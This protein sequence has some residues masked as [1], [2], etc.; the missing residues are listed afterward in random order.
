[1][2]RRDDRFPDMLS[3]TWFDAAIERMLRGEAV[4]EDVAPL[5]RVVD[6]MRVMADG[7]PPV[8]SPEL[9]ALLDGGAAESRGLATV[10]PLAPLGPRAAPRRSGGP[11]AKRSRAAE[12]RP[13]VAAL[14]VASKVALALG[15][16]SGVAASGAAGILPE[17]ATSVVRRAIEVMTPFELPDD[18]TAGPGQDGQPE[19]DAAATPRN[20]PNAP[21]PPPD[22]P[23]TTIP[24]N[25]AA[26]HDP[27]LGG[28]PGTG[29]GAPSSVSPGVDVSSSVGGDL[30]T[31]ASPSPAPTPT[32]TFSTPP[33]SG[34]PADRPS[35]L[36]EPAAHPPPGDDVPPAD[37]PHAGPP[38][39]ASPPEPPQP[40]SSL[41]GGTPPGSGSSTLNE[42]SPAAPDGPP[43]RSASPG[44]PPPVRDRGSPGGPPPSRPGQ[45]PSQRPSPHGGTDPAAGREPPPSGSS[46][47]VAGGTARPPNDP[48][49]PSGEGWPPSGDRP[50]GDQPPAGAAPGPETVG[51]SA[52]TAAPAHTAGP[53]HTAAP[54]SAGGPRP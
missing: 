11:D 22:A 1:M 44:G 25:A 39:P 34:H 32:T 13:R 14:G 53:A 15:F 9:A 26:V 33:G 37:P 23:S 54:A 27:S 35:T 10:T 18:A 21:L 6:D 12:L 51:P 17:P 47:P 8:P 48:G 7:Q 45:A 52:Q 20:Q 38:G 40:S 41:T 46:P 49:R 30:E 16:V 29:A 5:A 31:D 2:T 50:S 24:G 28:E 3:G 43:S 4:G 19:H 36:D 42:P